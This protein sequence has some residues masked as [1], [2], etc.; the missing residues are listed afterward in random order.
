MVESGRPATEIR[1]A[2]RMPR[3]AFIGTEHT[4][5]A[6]LT[7][8]WSYYKRTGA[9][10][11]DVDHIPPARLKLFLRPDLGYKAAQ[12]VTKRYEQEQAFADMRLWAASMN[13]AK[14]RQSLLQRREAREQVEDYIGL[15]R[16]RTQQ[17]SRASLHAASQLSGY[18]PCRGL[19]RA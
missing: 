11:E 1:Y 15:R 19:Q 5:T 4:G 13:R 10:W 2:S 6:P 18:V 12:L 8:N 3:T 14:L 16:P 17:A 9:L 7:K